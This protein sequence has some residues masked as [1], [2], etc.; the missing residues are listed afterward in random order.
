[1]S[2]EEAGAKLGHDLV[3]GWRRSWN[4]APP[5]LSTEDEF[6]WKDAP[7]AQPVT[8]IQHPAKS[9]LT[10][11]EKQACIPRTESLEDC[12]KRV[13][14]I[15]LQGIAPRVARGETVVVVAHANSIRSMIRHIDADTI[16]DEQVK[17]ISIPAATPLVYSFQFVDR[18]NRA[19]AGG[20]AR[21]G[22]RGLSSLSGN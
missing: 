7:W 4:L 1:M 19:S 13:K 21:S 14:P 18:S 11:F 8:L 15:W 20:S 17:S 3:M 2:K 9:T 16:T 6:F 10:A 22:V 5:P 12:A